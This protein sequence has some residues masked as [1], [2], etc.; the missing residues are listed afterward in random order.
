MLTRTGLP[1]SPSTGALRRRRLSAIFW[2]LAEIFSKRL[3]SEISS[4][5]VSRRA[6][7]PA[8]IA[9]ARVSRRTSSTGAA[10]SVVAAAGTGTTPA[11]TTGVVERGRDAFAAGAA[12]AAAAAAAGAAALAEALVG[13]GAGAATAAGTSSVFLVTRLTDFE[14]VATAELIILLEEVELDDILR[15][16]YHFC[17]QSIQLLVKHPILQQVPYVRTRLFCRVRSF[18]F[19]VVS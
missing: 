16:T 11:A 4:E 14:G 15:R 3:D 19:E 8:V 17:R 1:S 10:S 9:R 13:A 6:R 7:R 18:Y 12:G 5:R 2:V